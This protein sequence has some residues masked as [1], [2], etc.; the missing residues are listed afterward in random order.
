MIDDNNELSEN[1]T[2]RNSVNFGVKQFWKKSI[3]QKKLNSLKSRSSLRK[4]V[5]VIS[6][7]NILLI[8][9]WN[10]LKDSDSGHLLHKQEDVIL[11][12]DEK[13]ISLQMKLYSY[14]VK[15]IMTDSL[16]LPIQQKA[17]PV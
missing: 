14:L 5:V 11:D 15:E 8:N 12:T 13:T 6:H 4:A 1:W 17:R 16:S 9:F 7:P 2:L 3:F 10:I